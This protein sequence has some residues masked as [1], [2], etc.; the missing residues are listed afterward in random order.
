MQEDDFK[1]FCQTN[2]DLQEKIKG[3]NDDWVQKKNLCDSLFG[4]AGVTMKDK[5]GTAAMRTAAFF[6]GCPGHTAQALCEIFEDPQHKGHLSIIV[7]S[8][9]M[10]AA[11]TNKT[12]LSDALLDLI[13]E[14]DLHNEEIF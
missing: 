5:D 1:P 10:Y 13:K 7:Q 14:D 12:Y 6:T 4:I 8:L 9:L 3:I 2:K 11:T